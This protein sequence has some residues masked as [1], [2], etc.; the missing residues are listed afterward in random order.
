[1]Y[2]NETVTSV[3]LVGR[4]GRAPCGATVPAVGRAAHPAASRRRHRPHP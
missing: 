3:D 4:P 1:V 2:D